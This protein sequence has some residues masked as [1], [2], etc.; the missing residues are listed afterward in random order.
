MKEALDHWLFQYAPDVL[1]LEMALR[2]EE[3]NYFPVRAHFDRIKKGDKIILWQSGKN[4]AVYG[5]ARVAGDIQPLHAEKIPVRFR[6]AFPANQYKM[7]QVELE[8]N[9]W[10][11]PITRSRLQ[12]AYKDDFFNNLTG[13]TLKADALAY[14]QVVE[15][16]MHDQ[17]IEEPLP[18]YELP[19]V[20]DYPLNLILYGPPGTGKTYLTINHA[21]ATIEQKT[22][23]EIAVES[24]KALQKRFKA[25][26]EAGQIAMVTFHTSLAYEDFVEGIRPKVKQNQLTYEVE[27]G[28]FKKLCQKAAENQQQ[29][30]RFVLI[31]DEINRGNIANIFGELITLIE[32]DKRSAEAEAISLTLPY[33]KTDFSVPNNLYIIATMNTA[34]RTT[35]HMDTALRRRFA[36]KKINPKPELLRV[37]E[38]EARLGK[39]DLVQLLITL[40][41][42]IRRLLGEDH[43]LGH[44]YFM[45]VRDLDDLK[46]VF[47]ETI[48]P[49]LQVHF[50]GD[51]EKLGLILGK[52]FVKTEYSKGR[53]LGFAAFD[54][55]YANTYDKHR[56][57][58]LAAM[59]EITEADFIGI[60]KV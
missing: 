24:R 37:V 29:P 11:S 46:L 16:F 33:S 40:N 14:Q 36:F 50:F 59:D 52:G 9:L 49:Q 27:A 41:D 30:L 18:D 54:S 53:N 31:I 7:V 28:I 17:L 13:N 5:L 26:L 39:I 22:L 10:K 21:L 58:G 2:K 23:E 1:D 20:P 8:H 34:D 32:P 48:I 45:N 44:A 4:A 12:A 35:T 55:D 57:Y 42:R 51:L 19:A 38:R 3:L 6:T 60:Y 15:L 47:F 43:C 25:Y 56:S